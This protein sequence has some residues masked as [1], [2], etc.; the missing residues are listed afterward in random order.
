MKAHYEFPLIPTRKL[1]NGVTLIM[2]TSPIP[3]HPSTALIDKAIEGLRD[4]G[5][6]FSKKIISYDKPKKK[7]AAYETYKKIMKQ[8][9][10]DFV[11][12]EMKEH[13]HFIGSFYN[14]MT[15][16]DTKFV[17]MNQHDIEL[18]GVF[19]IQRMLRLPGKDWNIIATHHMK[20]GLTETHW[21]PIVRN[22][23]F[24]GLLKT[25]GWSERIFLTKTDYMMK[26]IYDGYH[27]KPTPLT[28]NF[29][30][31]VFHKQFGALYKQTQ[32]I[33]SYRDIDYENNKRV[34]DNYWNQWKTYNLKSS[35][36]YHKHLHGRTS[37]K[38]SRTKRYR[39]QKHTRKK[40][41]TRRRR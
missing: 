8:K 3:T 40:K 33:Q 11:H 24:P 28:V 39:K 35:I 37:R 13:G 34:Y 23:K 22:S 29:I 32:H 18:K 10:P 2:T 20:D 41:H 19:P 12:L 21:F 9:Y 31:S 16:C 14:A 7:V 5:Y 1:K 25:W 27:A 4:T 30:E 26:Q 38:A 15:H 17:F 6:K 36:C